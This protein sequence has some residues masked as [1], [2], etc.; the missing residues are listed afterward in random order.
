[1]WNHE[2]HRY[3]DITNFT[4]GRDLC[5]S[6]STASHGWAL[7]APAATGWRRWSTPAAGLELCWKCCPLRDAQHDAW[8]ILFISFTVFRCLPSILSH[9]QWPTLTCIS[10]TARRTADRLTTSVQGPNPACSNHTVGQAE[11][12][13]ASETIIPKAAWCWTGSLRLDE[14]PRIL[15]AGGRSGGLGGAL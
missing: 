14:R 4:R 8:W 6:A 11:G 15:L 3:V 12:T 1:M 10:R 9:T 2:V 13:R 5:V 7:A